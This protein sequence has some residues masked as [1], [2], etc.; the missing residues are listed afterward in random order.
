MT[1]LSFINRLLLGRP[2]PLRDLSVLKLG[3]G[4]S[5]SATIHCEDDTLYRIDLLLTTHIQRLSRRYKSLK[6]VLKIDGSLVLSVYEEHSQE[7]LRECVLSLSTIENNQLHTFTFNPLYNCQ[8]KTFKVGIRAEYTPNTVGVVGIYCSKT[9]DQV[10]GYSTYDGRRLKTRPLCLLFFLDLDKEKQSDSKVSTI[11]VN[12]NGL[13]YL[14][15]C[16]ESITKQT[17][18]NHEVILVDN[19][20]SDGSVG[21]IKD[22]YPE[23]E[24]IALPEN[25]EFV[26]AN[27]LG[28]EKS[29]GEYIM[30]LNPD[31]SVPSDF[32]ANMVE[33]LEL[34]SR[35]GAVGCNINTGGSFI[36]YASV[37]CKSN[38]LIAG[39]K[40]AI[41][42]P[43]YCLAP[44]GAAA[45]YRRRVLEELNEFFDDEFI[46]NWEDHDLGYR[47]NLY[48][49]WC[50]HNPD[51]VI[52][53]IGGA[54]Y[55][56]TIT[57]GVRIYRNMLLT[58]YKNMEWKNFVA[59]FFN[60]LL[61]P[62]HVAMPLGVC[63]FLKDITLNS[64][65]RAKR[66]LL[67]RSRKRSDAYIRMLTSGNCL[68]GSNDDR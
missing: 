57:R 45:I 65:I 18:P 59:A 13:K 14:D 1:V 19:A 56:I 10:T 23:I 38:G 32:V 20:S 33:T 2:F 25:L 40:T 48:G 8:G 17:Y 5:I 51:I 27:N 42:N 55:G 30:A 62:K 58:Y 29:T 4:H 12:H 36:R 22:N 43:V 63:L 16:L 24:L 34:H 11:V 61:R 49:Y 46:T 21:F 60:T 9:V 64:R 67:Q 28:L 37:F 47:I 31:T 41:S 7:V 52:D 44:C 53:H 54:A 35:V 39:S 68:W 15:K 66:K 50:L 26:V 3:A 6:G